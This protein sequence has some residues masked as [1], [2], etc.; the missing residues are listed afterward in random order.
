MQKTIKVKAKKDVMV[1]MEGQP[2]K[3]ITDKK[4][5]EVPLTHFYQRRLNDGTLIEQGKAQAGK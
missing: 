1:P 5:V 4:A 3:Y 2:R